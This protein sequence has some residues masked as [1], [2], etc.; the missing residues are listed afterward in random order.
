M[1]VKSFP[2]TLLLLAAVFL[3]AACAACVS[4]AL[5][6]RFQKPAYQNAHDWIHTQLGLTPEQDK[7]L[8]P[9]EKSYRSKRHDLEQQLVLANRELAEA[10]LADGQDSIRVHKAIEKIH[11]SM[12]DL[13]KVTIGHVFEMKP[14]L[15]EEQYQKLLNLT[16]NALYNLDSGHAAE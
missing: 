13:Q 2:S 1:A 11:A 4:I 14:V 9:I 10:I 6:P 3:V 8:I 5:Y 7:L 15:S 12:G 16:A